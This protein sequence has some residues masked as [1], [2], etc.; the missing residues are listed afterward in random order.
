[1]R[2]LLF[3]LIKIAVTLVLLF[4]VISKYEVSNL[5]KADFGMMALAV[6]IFIL[7]N[8][9]GAFQWQK[10]LHG[11]DIAFPYS[12]AANLYFIGLFFNNFLPSSLGGDVV[13]IYSVSRVEKRGREGLAAT[14]VDRFAGLFLLSLFAL[15]ASTWLLVT[16]GQSVKQDILVYIAIVFVIFILV[17]AFLFSRRIGRLVYEVLLAPFNPLGLKDKFRKGHEFFHTYRHQYRLAGEVFILSLAIQLARV[18][19]HYFCALSIGFDIDFIYF[20]LF[21]PI[22]AMAAVIPISF[23]GL[24][25]RESTAPFLFTSM[26]AVAAVDP[27]GSLAV[28][29][30]LLA[31]LVG[32]VVGLIGGALFILT[33]TSGKVEVPER[34]SVDSAG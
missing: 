1:M 15:G 25:V 7:S 30:Q 9:L 17:T 22:I 8:F 28:T 34:P 11:Q 20:L 23:G 33:R 6:G 10:L 31:S 29:T 18:G 12:R 13:K 27:Q 14:F 2:R 24:G 5:L 3:P 32:I 19:V 21:V 4:W 16:V 26:A